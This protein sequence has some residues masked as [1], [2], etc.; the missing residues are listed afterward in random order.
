MRR[1]VL[2][3]ALAACAAVAPSPAAAAMCF[4]FTLD[5][6]PPRIG[7][8]T[9]VDVRTLWA[10]GIERFSLRVWSPSRSTSV[11]ELARLAGEERWRGAVVFE[12]PGVWAL[13]AE[14]AVPSNEYPCFYKEIEIPS[15]AVD[16]LGEATAPGV[17]AVVA[18]VIGVS[19]LAGSVVIR[20]R[21]RPAG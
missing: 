17:A 11:V 10:S 1:V 5:P 20:V 14:M 21:G 7:E 12:T 19:V 4:E 8:V 6:N 9:T 2:A 13:Q 3:V 15:A 16:G 18:I